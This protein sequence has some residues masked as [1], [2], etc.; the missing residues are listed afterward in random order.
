MKRLDKTS[1]SE[2]PEFKARRV[3]GHPVHLCLEVS[4]FVALKSAECQLRKGLQIPA[5]TGSHKP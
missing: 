3:D 5:S 2:N 4:S 1:C